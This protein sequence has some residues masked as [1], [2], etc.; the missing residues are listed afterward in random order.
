[1]A[2]KVL[3]VEDDDFTRLS[4]A[5]TLK[6]EGFDVFDAASASAAATHAHSWWPDIAVLDLHLGPGP[7]GI[8]LARV[9]RR[10]NPK[11]GIVLLTSYDDPRMLST[12]LPEPPAGSQYL[13]K[14]SV[15][16]P[17]DLLTAMV[18]SVRSHIVRPATTGS[19]AFTSLTDHQ[20][21]VLRL[22][23]EGYSNQHIAAE[24]GR[25]VK[26]VESSITRLVKALSLPGGSELNQRVLLTRAYLASKTSDVTPAN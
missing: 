21:D 25:T 24:L 23:A 3:V 16:Q 14:R 9:L 1:M 4:I 20:H 6:A 2:H 5:Q 26:A 13:T 17:N 19:N 22:V 11:I 12:S 15:T 18:S 10:E 7:T 8:D